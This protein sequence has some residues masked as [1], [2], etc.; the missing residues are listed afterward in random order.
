MYRASLNNILTVSVNIPINKS[1]GEYD[2]EAQKILLDKYKRIETIRTTLIDSI[3]KI[4][5]CPIDYD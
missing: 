4:V 3:G 1:T 2:V 5:D